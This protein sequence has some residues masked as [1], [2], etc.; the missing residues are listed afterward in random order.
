M[1]KNSILF[2]AICI[3]LIL[4]S[5]SSDKDEISAK[6]Q[7]SSAKNNVEW[8]AYKTTE[9]TPV[10]GTFSSIEVTS[11]GEGNTLKEAIENVEFNIPI[12]SVKSEGREYN[13]I[14]FFFKAMDNTSLLSGK[15]KL[16]DDTTG[17]VEITMNGTRE[18][19]PFTYTI[20]GEK[21]KLNATM[22]LSKWKADKAIKSLNNQCKLLHQGSDGITKL[23][24][25][26]SLEITSNFNQ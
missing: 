26:V 14:N 9:K 5:C 11:H 2:I 13:I 17:Y 25:D 18:N 7:L 24:N 8:T 23:W 4:S 6:Y 10:K 19:L 12:S 21:F 15:I 16:T 20:E 1:Q 3:V 22:D